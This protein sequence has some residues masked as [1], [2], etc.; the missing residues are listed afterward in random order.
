MELSKDPLAAAPLADALVEQSPDAVMFADAQG[1]IRVWNGRAEQVFAYSASD[2]LDHS[3]NITIT[4]RL[5]A[6]HWRG[7]EAALGSSQT[8][9]A[10]RVLTTRAVHKDGRTLYVDLSFALVEDASG[11]IL[12]VLATARDSTQRYLEHK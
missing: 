7:F 9:Y 3:L 2:A 4:D 11:A 6:V 10:G 5:R 1:A 8:K 12:G